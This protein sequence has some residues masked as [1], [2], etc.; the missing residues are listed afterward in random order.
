MRFVWASMD[1]TPRMLGPLAALSL[2]FVRP[3]GAC[4]CTSCTQERMAISQMLCLP[5]LGQRERLSTQVVVS[6]L[7]AQG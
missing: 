2:P 4:L 6:A 1:Q 3:Q 7:V 5:P